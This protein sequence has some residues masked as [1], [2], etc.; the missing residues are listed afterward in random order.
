MGCYSSRSWHGNSTATR[1][2]QMFC[3]LDS[4]AFN[5]A[6]QLKSNRNCHS[7]HTLRFSGGGDVA[8]LVLLDLCFAFATVDY[9]IMSKQLQFTYGLNGLVLTWLHS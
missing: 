4:L 2:G 5:Q 8:A 3:C 9:S 1:S 6:I 7:Q